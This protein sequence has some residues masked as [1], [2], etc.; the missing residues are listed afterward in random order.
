MLRKGKKA[1]TN[2]I[3]F[4]FQNRS[5]S[6]EKD[7]SIIIRQHCSNC[8][9]LPKYKIFLGS[10]LQNP[11]DPLRYE[12][13]K[14]LYYGTIRWMYFA[15]PMRLVNFF[16]QFQGRSLDYPIC[17]SKDWGLHFHTLQSTNCVF[18]FSYAYFPRRQFCM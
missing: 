12:V 2:M 13:K 11:S 6:I 16:F 4:I 3:E 14:I 15:C 5:I 9:I 8:L 18:P 7:Y 1:N 10:L 17:R